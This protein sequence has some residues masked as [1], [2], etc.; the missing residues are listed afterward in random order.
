MSIQLVNSS[1]SIKVSAS[2]PL[3]ANKNRPLKLFFVGQATKL[4]RILAQSI[5]NKSG[6]LDVTFDI[7]LDQVFAD[8][9]QRR[10]NLKA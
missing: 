9:E 8:E 4:C 10:L 1:T 6:V 7:L 5:A 3:E 2:L